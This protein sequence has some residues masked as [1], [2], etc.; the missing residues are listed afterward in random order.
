MTD[1]SQPLLRLRA[2][3]EESSR[4]LCGFGR[5]AKPLPPFKDVGHPLLAKIGRMR[6]APMERFVSEQE[7]EALTARLSSMEEQ[8]KLIEAAV[9]DTDDP[10][11][12]TEP[13]EDDVA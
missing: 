6:I 5:R 3:L 13:P 10:E 9:L 11:D 2:L 1:I 4:S 7:Y 8:I 12:D